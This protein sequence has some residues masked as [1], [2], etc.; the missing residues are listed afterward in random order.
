[1][2]LS[3]YD[4]QLIQKS[5][6]KGKA[7]TGQGVDVAQLL[8]DAEETADILSVAGQKDAWAISFEAQNVMLSGFIPAVSGTQ[9]AIL[10]NPTMVIGNHKWWP[11]DSVISSPV[12]F[13]VAESVSVQFRGAYSLV[14]DL[15]NSAPVVWIPQSPLT[16][17]KV[18]QDVGFITNFMPER[19]WIHQSGQGGEAIQAEVIHTPGGGP[20]ATQLHLQ[21]QMRSWSSYALRT[22]RPRRS[23]NLTKVQFYSEGALVGDETFQIEV[24]RVRD[25]NTDYNLVASVTAT[26]TNQTE[27]VLL[28]LTIDTLFD[29]ILPTDILTTYVNYD[30]GT[31]SP[32]VLFGFDLHFEMTP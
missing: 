26:P 14:N 25:Y 18:R 5:L 31:L 9:R 24:Y 29:D 8:E 20:L 3:P 28:D 19:Y 15:F 10:S 32:A 6:L 30:R 4:K 13:G 23:G 17:G 2:P 22:F 16:V 1:M 27:G 11:I 21:M 7:L 12:T